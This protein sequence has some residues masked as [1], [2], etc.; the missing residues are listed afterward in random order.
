MNKRW[1]M[2]FMLVFLAVIT[3]VQLQFIQSMAKLRCIDEDG[4]YETDEYCDISKQCGVEVKD[5]DWGILAAAYID[6]MNAGY[7]RGM[8]S[9]VRNSLI[10]VSENEQITIMLAKKKYKKLYEAMNKI[11][12]IA[13]EIK[14]FPVA[15]FENDDV[16]VSYIDSWNYA[17][18]YGGERLHKG[19]DIMSG[20]N[21][22]GYFPVVSVTDG[23]IKCMGWLELGGMRI[24][25]E[26]ESGAYYY[27]AHLHSYASGLK[28]GDI[29]KAGQ[30]I[31]FMGDTGYG[32][33]GT[34]GQFDVHL[35]FGIYVY[36][37]DNEYAL[38]PYPMLE[39]LDERK[40]RYKK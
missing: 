9:R 28:E 10:Y 26:S 24:G 6:K 3:G 36:D 7:D 22:P 31:G 37:E 39:I 15:E 17:R 34:T 4:I 18:T 16:S 32:P 40:L 23:T 12:D 19:T 14:Y 1:Y 2:V 33:E 29:V 21:V 27:Y 13:G 38:N 25:I 35:H 20:N 5:S 30:L 8:S 11:S